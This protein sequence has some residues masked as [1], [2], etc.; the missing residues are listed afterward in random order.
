MKS[1]K[2]IKF[3]T[4]RNDVFVYTLTT[5]AKEKKKKTLTKEGKPKGILEDPIEGECC[6]IY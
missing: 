2:S 1:S 4:N 6:Q 3:N 5:E